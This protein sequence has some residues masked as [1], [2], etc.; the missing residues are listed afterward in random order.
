MAN[1]MWTSVYGIILLILASIIQVLFS[2]NTDRKLLADQRILYASDNRKQIARNWK[3]AYVH[4]PK[5]GGTTMEDSSLFDRKRKLGM[6]PRSHFS[7]RALKNT[8]NVENF[9]F[10]THIRH[11]CERFVSA[12]L[13]LRYDSRAKAMRDLA[14]QYGVFDFLTVEDFIDWIDERQYWSSLLLSGSLFHFRPMYYWILDDCSESFGIDI[15]MCQDHWKD[16]IHNLAQFLKMKP[17]PKNLFA[18]KRVNI[19]HNSSCVEMASKYSQ[20]IL[21]KYSLDACLFGYEEFGEGKFE[22]P[23]WN[24]SKCIGSEFDKAWFTDRLH[25]CKDS[26]GISF[27]CEDFTE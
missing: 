14:R 3:L 25:F 23:G 27:G 19:F 18:K 15:V 11:P 24:K 13:Y 2:D 26:L 12:F 7:I 10:A 17:I 21:E 8:S 20:R 5:T 22:I 16:G 6:A 9:L 1:L 4:I